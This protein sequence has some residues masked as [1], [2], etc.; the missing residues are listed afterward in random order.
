MGWFSVAIMVAKSW[1]RQG[2][3]W[4]LIQFVKLG[5]TAFKKDSDVEYGSGVA[6]LISLEGHKWKLN[7][8][9]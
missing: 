9:R 6:Q 7:Y 3:K 4:T 1:G 2:L 8:L 5:V